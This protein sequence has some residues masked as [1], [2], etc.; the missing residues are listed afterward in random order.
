MFI[1][2]LQI[3]LCGL[4]QN[5]F[6]SFLVYCFIVEKQISWD[7]DQGESRTFGLW[8]VD[9]QTLLRGSIESALSRTEM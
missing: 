4:P 7:H 3:V 1:N 9:S 8:S 5:I 2:Y 6:F